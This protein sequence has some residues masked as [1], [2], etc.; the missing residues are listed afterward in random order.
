MGDPRS[1]PSIA[2]KESIYRPCRTRLSLHT[3]C[4]LRFRLSSLCRTW[5]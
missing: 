3:L 1:F 2:P 4:S 5:Y